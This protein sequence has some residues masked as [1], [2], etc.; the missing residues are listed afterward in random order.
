MDIIRNTVRKNLMTEKG[1]S[2]YCGSVRCPYIWPRTTQFNGQQFE[3]PCGWVSD[4]PKSFIN[5]YKKKW[6]L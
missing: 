4:F 6:G 1:Y 3:C 2:P 5:E